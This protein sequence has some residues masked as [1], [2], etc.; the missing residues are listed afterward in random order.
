VGGAGAAALPKPPASPAAAGLDAGMMARQ[1]DSFVGTA[2]TG[3]AA[4]PIGSDA[5]SVAEFVCEEDVRQAVKLGRTIVIGE[6]TIIT[7]AARDLASAHQVFVS[8][9]WPR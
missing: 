8:A 3:A 1:V 6:R 2:R 9:T 5:G 7:P 4:S